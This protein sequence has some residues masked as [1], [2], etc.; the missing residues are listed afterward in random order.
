MNIKSLRTLINEYRNRTYT[1]S[2][3]KEQLAVAITHLKEELSLNIESTTKTEIL[4][5]L[6]KAWKKNDGEEEVEQYMK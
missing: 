1:P 2:D 5:S 4:T 3:N 6:K